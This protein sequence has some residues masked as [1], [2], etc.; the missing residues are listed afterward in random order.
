M[1]MKLSPA[2]KRA[3]NLIRKANTQLRA[4]VKA[5]GAQS[6]E[7]RLMEQKVMS[8]FGGQWGKYL[9]KDAKTGAT[10]IRRTKG[11]VHAVASRPD[12]K[13]RSAEGK[14]VYNIT[15]QESVESKKKRLLSD[16][17]IRTGTKPKSKAEKEQAI[18]EQRAFL[19]VLSANFGVHLDEL[20]KLEQMLGYPLAVIAKIRTL[21]QGAAT[22]PETLQ[23]M[24]DLAVEELMKPAD[25]HVADTSY[26]SL[27]AAAQ[28]PN[29]RRAKYWK[30]YQGTDP[31][32][33]MEV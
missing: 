7:Y 11:N 33:G 8:A 14:A 32:T 28:D 12:G 6:Q 23:Q 10:Q 17:Q 20:Y 21:S 9:T 16:Y 26:E 27:R 24:D 5:F 30:E 13:H 4:A 15:Q 25:Q 22:S 31:V 1:A 19:N 18:K 29:S 3:D 2:E